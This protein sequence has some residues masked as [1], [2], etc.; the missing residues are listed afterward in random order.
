M[1][2]GCPENRLHGATAACTSRQVL[3]TLKCG[4]KENDEGI[5]VSPD[6][7]C[8]DSWFASVKAATLVKQAGHEQS[9]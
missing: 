7:F 6:T 1:P 9:T 3:A 2:I 4:E 8:G 5:S